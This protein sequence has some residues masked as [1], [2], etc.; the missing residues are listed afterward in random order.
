MQPMVVTPGGLEDRPLDAMPSQPGAQ[1]PA[2]EPVVR[3]VGSGNVVKVETEAPA[4]RRKPSATATPCILDKRPSPRLYRRHQTQSTARKGRAGS[5]S[6]NVNEYVLDRNLRVSGLNQVPFADSE[7][8][9]ARSL[10]SKCR[11]LSIVPP[12]PGINKLDYSVHWH[13]EYIT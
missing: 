12:N 4:P 10:T 13:N 1:R 5:M 8:T 3:R 9:V 2:A 6:T 7:R 11:A